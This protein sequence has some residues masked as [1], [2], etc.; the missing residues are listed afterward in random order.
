VHHIKSKVL[1]LL[2]GGKEQPRTAGIAEIGGGK[3][4]VEIML[5]VQ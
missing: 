2:Q 4:G 3:G 1:A 5:G